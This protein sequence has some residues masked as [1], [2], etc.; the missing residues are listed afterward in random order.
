MYHINIIIYINNNILIKQVIKY[1]NI[2][3]INGYKRIAIQIY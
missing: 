2:T 3:F 1:I